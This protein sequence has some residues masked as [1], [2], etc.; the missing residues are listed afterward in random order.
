MSHK[1]DDSDFSSGAT[2]LFDQL[3]KQQSQSNHIPVEVEK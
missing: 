1:M 2:G 3:R